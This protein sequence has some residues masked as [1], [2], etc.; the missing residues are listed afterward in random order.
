MSRRHE[1]R[2]LLPRRQTE[3]PAREL[4]SEVT[5]HGRREATFLVLVTLFVASI[6]CL[7]VLGTSRVI[8]VNATISALVPD[9]DLP[10]S[11]ALPFGAIPCALG[12]VAVMLASELYGRRR[13]GALVWAGLVTAGA[14]VGLARLA[15]LSDGADASFVPALALAAGVVVAHVVNLLVFDALRRRLAGR[16]AVVRAFAASLW[17]QP[18]GWAAFGGVLYLLGEPADLDRITALALGSAAYTFACVLL[19]AVPLAI[20]A[21]TLALYLRVARFEPGSRARRLAPALVVDENEEEPAR[22]ADGSAEHAPAP[23]R[24]R[25]AARASIQPFSAAEMRFFTE[26]DQLGDSW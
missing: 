25:R 19:L 4:V 22:I 8:D 2:W 3:Y 21:R 13:A 18:A 7:V 14:L 24:R 9:A 20:A 15:D 11:L 10:I 12:F 5:L 6:T 16:H 17:A 23:P 1:D 26:G